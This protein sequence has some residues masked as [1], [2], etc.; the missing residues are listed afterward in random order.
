MLQPD[1]RRPSSPASL[2]R[3]R[4]AAPASET[5]AQAWA[6]YDAHGRLLRTGFDAPAAWPG[7][8][9]AEAIVAA[10]SVRIAVVTLPPL[11]P[12]RVRAAA[13]FAVE[14]QLAGAP[15]TQHVAASRQSA[16]G[17]VRVVIVEQERIAAIVALPS[18]LPGLPAWRRVV[19]EPELAPVD[20]DWHW[21]SGEDPAGDA[22]ARLADGVSI[23]LPPPSAGALP[24][25]LARLVERRVP[26]PRAV[27]VHAEIDD[28][29]L[30]DWSAATGIRFY[31]QPRWQWAACP[32]AAYAAATELRQG[33]LA[34]VSAPTA[35]GARRL[36]RPAIAIAAAALGLHVAATLVEWAW[37][38]IDAAQTAAAWRALATGAGV[39]P[40]PAGDARAALTRRY[41]EL[42][43]GSGLAA[44][45]DPLPTLARA[46]PVLSRLPPGALKSAS[47]A[48]GAWT[49]DLGNLDADALRAFDAGMKA[50]GVPALIA[51]SGGNVRARFGGPSS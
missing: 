50:A 22:F 18:T 24:V 38:R 28:A 11:A 34:T 3:V 45:D 37:L 46:A 23:P 27:A 44:P 21:C 32:P 43:H 10:A 16:D 36:W 35:G 13:A 7:A 15:G 8:D 33:D 31:A 29:T 41:A 1:S 51:R 40:G 26:P 47:Y 9:A 17:S 25:E 48:G 2:L 20:L 19:A 6:L 42:R 4:F 49:V 39:D 12:A 5:A 30:A 14:D